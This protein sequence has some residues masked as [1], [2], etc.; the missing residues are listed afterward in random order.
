[1]FVDHIRIVAKAGNGGNGSASY[2]RGKGEPKGGPDGGDGGRGGDVILKVDPHTDNLKAF[3][4]QP[5]YKAEPGNNGAKNQKTGRSGKNLILKVPPGTVVYRGGQAV[6]AVPDGGGFDGDGLLVDQDEA[7]SPGF[8]I[9]PEEQ[10]LATEPVVDLTEA[11]QTFVLCKGGRGGKGNVHFKSST[12]RAPVEVEAGGLGEEACFYLELRK[13]ADAGLVGFPNA[14][15]STLLRALSAAKP[16]V[17]A[18]PF[19]TLKPMVGVVEFRGFSRA[20]IADI[21]G[22]IEGAHDNVG[23]GHEFLRHIMRCRLLMFVVDMAGAEDGSRHPVGDIELLR[24]EIKLYHE[25][26]ATRPWVIVANK[27]DLPGSQAN[28]AVVRQRF[29]KIEVIPISGGDGT[30]LGDLKERL[31]ELIGRRPE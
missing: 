9:V 26:L 29:A 14:G 12:N 16:K 30:G 4:Y 3:F 15:K 18:Y 2:R 27:M 11:G 23:L 24:K 13:I 8:D 21:P 6:E 1:M 19:T 7:P 10:A 5:R 17:A 31:Q 22:L 20:T 28:L 25:D